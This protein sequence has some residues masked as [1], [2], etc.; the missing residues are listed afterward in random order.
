MSKVVL[1]N[2][3]D[4][5]SVVA[6]EKL[7]WVIDVLE[8]LGVSEEVYNAKDISNFRYD[9]DKLGIDVEYITSGCVNIYKKHWL[10]GSTEERSGWLPAKEEHLV[11]Q[12]KEPKY[13]RKI[14]AKGVYY[15]IQLNEWSIANMRPN[16]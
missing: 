7:Y 8:A 13:A 9:M 3:S 12:W 14:D 1:C 4:S 16:K 2:V 10:E 15:E 11:A 6:E 5:H